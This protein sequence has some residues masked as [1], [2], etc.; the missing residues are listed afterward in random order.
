MGF[1]KSVMASN[2][3]AERARA[4]LSRQELAERSGVSISSIKGYEDG[5]NVMSIEVAWA[6][7]DALNVSIGT[8]AGRDESRYSGRQ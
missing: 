7:A 5:E 8:I 2:L 4:N 1:E 6:L 3:R